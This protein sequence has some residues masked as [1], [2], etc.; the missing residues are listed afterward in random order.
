MGEKTEKIFY[1]L[2]CAAEDPEKASVP[3]VLGCAALAMDIGATICLQGKGSLYGPERIR[4]SHAG[5][6][7]FPVHEKADEGFFGAGR[8]IM[9]LRALHQ[10]A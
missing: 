4:Q 6:R 10:R 3:F 1:L 8:K 2:T 5:W 7:R 9:G